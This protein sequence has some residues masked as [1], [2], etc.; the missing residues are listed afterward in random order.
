LQ[1]VGQILEFDLSATQDF[2][3]TF[4]LNNPC[5]CHAL[6]RAAVYQR[7]NRSA[8][9]FS[10]VNSGTSFPVSFPRFLNFIELSYSWG[11]VI[12]LDG[13]EQRLQSGVRPM[14]GLGRRLVHFA[15][16][17][18]SAECNF[19]KRF[20]FFRIAGP[21]LLGS[22]GSIAK[23]FGQLLDLGIRIST[24]TLRPR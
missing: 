13:R 22:L 23:D 12:L 9:I 10:G 17:N 18:R 16:R 21:E 19:S 4:Q 6:Q 14:A 5:Y 20:R 2:E 24:E 3:L 8:L 11:R 15:L 1:V 7:N